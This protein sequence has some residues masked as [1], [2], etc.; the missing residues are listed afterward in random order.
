MHLL[1]KD[2]AGICGGRGDG[3]NDG[4]QMHGGQA[5]SSPQRKE[6]GVCVCVRVCTSLY[7]P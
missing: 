4:G 5:K 3:L 2:E 6:G 1:S 7:T